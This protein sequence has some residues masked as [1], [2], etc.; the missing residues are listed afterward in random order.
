MSFGDRFEGEG[1]SF[2]DVLLLPQRTDTLPRD[3]DT[4]TCVAR[5]VD[6]KIPLVSSPMD[7]VSEARMAIAIAREGGL[8]D[9][10]SEYVSGTTGDRG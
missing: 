9:T 5:G 6:L 4:S 8:G 3:C 2:D 7:T 1:L 10:P